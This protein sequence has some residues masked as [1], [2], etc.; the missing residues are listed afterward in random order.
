MVKTWCDI[1]PDQIL[2]VILA[3]QKFNMSRFYLFPLLFN[4]SNLGK[5]YLWYT[6]KVFPFGAMYHFGTIFLSF[7]SVPENEMMSHVPFWYHWMYLIP[8]KKQEGQTQ[9]NL[10]NFTPTVTAVPTVKKTN[11]QKFGH[12]LSKFSFT[13]RPTQP[14]HN[15]L[16]SQN[17]YNQKVCL[18]EFLNMAAS[19]LF[20]QPKITMIFHLPRTLSLLPIFAVNYCVLGCCR[21]VWCK[22]GR[23]KNP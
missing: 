2:G 17:G 7:N 15:S 22:P 19:D 14:K 6:L 18:L 8:F 5:W 4:M 10:Q 20:L 13:Q 1:L 3:C 23:G 21:L 11:S 16:L 9:E 12:K